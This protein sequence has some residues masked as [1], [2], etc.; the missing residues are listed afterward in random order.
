MGMQEVVLPFEW[1]SFCISINIAIKKVAV[2]HNGHIQAVQAFPD[3]EEVKTENNFKIL[4]SGHLGGEKFVGI[5]ADFEVFGR[6]MPDQ[7]MLE[8]TLC[9]NEE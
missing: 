5:V 9:Q 1:H 2:F 3:T 4:T 6:P 8:W 7:E